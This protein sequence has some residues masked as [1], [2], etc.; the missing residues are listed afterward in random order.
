MMKREGVAEDDRTEKGHHHTHSMDEYTKRQSMRMMALGRLGDGMNV[1]I[2]VSVM[3]GQ[4]GSFT[5]FSHLVSRPFGVMDGDGVTGKRGHGMVMM[6]GDRGGADDDED[7]C[8]GDGEGEG[9]GR[10]GTRGLG[11]KEEQ[12]VYREEEKEEKEEEE[13]EDIGKRDLSCVVYIGD[14][15]GSCWIVVRDRL[16]AILE[17]KDTGWR[18]ATKNDGMVTVWRKVRD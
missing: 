7:E 18:L 12:V 13:E 8:G 6:K 10:E 2:G 16:M 11:V 9:M 1:G 17:D 14:G 3:A 4:V 15:T 5:R